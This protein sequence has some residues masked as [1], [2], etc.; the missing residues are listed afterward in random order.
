MNLETP[1]LLVSMFNFLCITTKVQAARLYLLLAV[2]QLT[3]QFLV[4]C[5]EAI[6]IPG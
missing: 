5:A 3:L 1:L 6:P 4:S 2:T